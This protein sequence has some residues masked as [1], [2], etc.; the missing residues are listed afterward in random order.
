[1]LTV[2]GVNTSPPLRTNCPFSEN[3]IRFSWKP[4]ADLRLV[5]RLLATDMSIGSESNKVVTVVRP[6]LY[7]RFP[8]VST[9]P[10]PLSDR[11]TFS[12]LRKPKRFLKKNIFEILLATKEGSGLVMSSPAIRSLREMSCSL[13]ESTASFI[14]NKGIDV[15]STPLDIPKPTVST[16]L[17]SPK[18]CPLAVSNLT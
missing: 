17:P 13:K 18:D 10:S 16:Q 8:E 6:K 14:S 11:M 5:T 2:L 9:A 3:K 4:L 12:P 15:G 7:S 1:M